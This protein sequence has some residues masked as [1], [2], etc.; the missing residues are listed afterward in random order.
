M[1]NEQPT[2]VGADRRRD[3]ER[4]EGEHRVDAEDAEQDAQIGTPTCQQPPGGCRR[5]ARRPG[6][7]C[8]TG[9]SPPGVLNA[10]HINAAAATTI[11]SP[12]ASVRIPWRCH[13]R[14][15]A[16]AIPIRAVISS[17]RA[18]R[19]AA[20]T[21]A[22]S[23]SVNFRRPAC[24]ATSAARL[25]ARPS[26][27]GYVPVSTGSGA[28]NANAT[29]GHVATL[30]QRVWM[31]RLNAAAAPATDAATIVAVPRIAASG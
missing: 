21:R 17:S 9:T 8:R 30:A 25:S 14:G 26:R 5:P 29:D 16:A 22:A 13:H 11:A 1:Y 31:I 12:N 15:V 27:N 7:R 24:S 28:R 10:R 3:G 4:R 19:C 20:A 18:S 6:R 23:A 2:D